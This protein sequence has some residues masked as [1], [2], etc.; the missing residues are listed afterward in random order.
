MV[1]GRCGAPIAA[2]PPA[3]TIKTM[4]PRKPRGGAR[5]LETRWRELVRS[6][7]AWRGGYG[8]VQEDANCE[9][10]EQLA[11]AAQALEPH[12]PRTQEVAVL[13]VADLVTI[14]G[15]AV[16]DSFGT[17]AEGVDA[18]AEAFTPVLAGCS[19]A[20]PQ[21]AEAIAAA[22]TMSGA[23]YFVFAMSGDWTTTPFG[24]WLGAL[25]PDFAAAVATRIDPK[26]W[27]DE[28]FAAGMVELAEQRGPA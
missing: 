10:M 13:L 20:L 15:L 16:D 4:T 26:S 18:V 28:D 22:A 12:L 14:A 3:G 19:G 7:P 23:E 8:M 11:E 5:T 17:L 9:F 2:L 6:G 24:M 27:L 1:G 25:G 21:L